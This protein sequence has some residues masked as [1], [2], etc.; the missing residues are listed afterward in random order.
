M[1]ISEGK[2]KKNERGKND[3]KD[4]QTTMENDQA[5]TSGSIPIH[6][7]T[8]QDEDRISAT[9]RNRRRKILGRNKRPESRGSI[10]ERLT[11]KTKNEGS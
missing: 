10:I 3:R 2:V 7:S 6:R 4:L 9:T 8:Q 5:E 11:E 1:T